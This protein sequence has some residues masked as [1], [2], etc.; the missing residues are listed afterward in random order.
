MASMPCENHRNCFF[1]PVYRVWSVAQSRT[2]GALARASSS[3]FLRSISASSA[4]FC[5]GVF[6]ASSAALRAR[7]AAIRLLAAATATAPA[8]LL[9]SSKKKVVST[10][11]GASGTR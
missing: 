11:W 10:L 1:H 2:R 4:S 5:S 6:F 3:A 9:I 8:I 7:S